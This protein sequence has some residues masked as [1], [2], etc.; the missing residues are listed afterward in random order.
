MSALHWYAAIGSVLLTSGVVRMFAATDPLVRLVAL[1]VAGGGGL[2]LVVTAAAAADVPDPIPHALALTGIV[3][4]VAF[5][6][7][8]LALARRIESGDT[9]RADDELGLDGPSDG[10]SDR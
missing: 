2:V 1:N 6:A 5:T 9:G 7:V 4:T 10:G 8:G 3:I